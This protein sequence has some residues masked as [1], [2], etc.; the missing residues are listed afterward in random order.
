MP[1]HTRVVMPTRIATMVFTCS[2]V[3]VPRIPSTPMAGVIW[4]DEFIIVEGRFVSFGHYLQSS[5]ATLA[6]LS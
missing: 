5:A 3:I 2:R 1:N 6:S 4:L